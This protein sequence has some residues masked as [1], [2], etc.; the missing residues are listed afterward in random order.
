MQVE[1]IGDAWMGVTN[2]ENDQEYTHVKLIAEMAVDMVLAAKKV[3]VDVD[4]PSK[5][6][7]N[8]RV[9]FHSG[10][11]KVMVIMKAAPF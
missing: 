5:G 6:F 8:I 2:L 11:S 9:G 7:V 1:T 10:V 4:D 3:L